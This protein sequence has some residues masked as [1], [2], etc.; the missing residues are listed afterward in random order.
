[1]IESC[2]TVLATVC[3]T[4]S[5]DSLACCGLQWLKYKKIKITKC[6]TNLGKLNL[7]MVVQFYTQANNFA[8][9][10]ATSKK[11]KLASKLV[12]IGSK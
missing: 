6:F 5:W 2:L 11:M 9:A 1:M 4:Y 8:T 7:T 10:P 12:K 3:T